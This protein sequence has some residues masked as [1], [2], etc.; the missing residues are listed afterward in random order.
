MFSS[1]LLGASAKLG[2]KL[3]LA[4]SAADAA[5]K[6]ADG[7]R[8][9]IVDLTLAGLDLRA[10]VSAARERAK[11]A[12]IVAFGPHVDEQALAAAEKAGAHVVM[13]RGQFHREYAGLL[14]GLVAK[15]S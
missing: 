1:Q 3:T 2:L 5:A 7:C 15:G 13:S 8:L 4:T 14:A 11:G 6:M 10:V 12:R 9:V